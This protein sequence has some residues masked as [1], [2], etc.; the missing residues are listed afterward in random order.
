[1][2]MEI[3]PAIDLLG[4][5]CVRLKQGDYR[6]ET[7]FSD[8]PVSVAQSWKDQGATRLHLVDLDGAKDGSQIN[9]AVIG[10]IASEVG[11]TCQVGGGVRDK[12]AVTRLI[13]L[14]VER[15]IVGTRAVRE[16]EWFCE[17]T[18][19]YPSRLVLGLDAR[20]GMVATDGWLNTSTVTAV[21]LAQQIASST[22]QVAAIVYTD[23][24]RDG[25]MS[26]PNFDQLLQMQQATNIPVVCSGGVT[27]MSDI[28]QLLAMN[29]HAAIIGRT[30][31]EGALSLAE[32]IHRCRA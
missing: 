23:I 22:D 18:H 27:S 9:A 14:G 5:K 13:S 10:R 28:E 26:G 6:Q 31:Y 21:E 17:M 2:K 3:W 24:A 29:T 4:G 32:V 1:M 19:Q 25:M 15:V 16:P 20:D 8:D 12:A 30:L 11:L 7:V